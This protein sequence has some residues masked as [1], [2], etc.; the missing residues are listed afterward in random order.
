[1]LLLN[2]D[3]HIAEL[4]SHM[5]RGQFVRNTLYAVTES[6]RSSSPTASS[7][8]SLNPAA[9]AST[10]DLPSHSEEVNRR[11]SGESSDPTTLRMRS[12]RS[13]SI[14]SW[15]SGSREAV[16]GMLGNASTPAL[17]SSQANG[18]APSND[19]SK[20]APATVRGPPVFSR[21]WELEME[22]LLKVCDET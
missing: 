21:Q 1:M 9:R 20:S 6:A 5:S 7:H 12:K 16:S 8:P 10:P 13:G 4:A 2:T 18:A 11:Q 14:T 3:L 19:P 17:I 15:K 22:N